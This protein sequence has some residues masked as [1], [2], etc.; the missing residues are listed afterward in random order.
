MRILTFNV[1]NSEFYPPQ[2]R[3]SQLFA[4]FAHQPINP[5]EMNTTEERALPIGTRLTSPTGIYIIEAVLGAGGFG[6]T[7]RVMSRIRHMNIEVEA[8]FAIK[9]MF[10]GDVCERES[11][12]GRMLYSTPVKDRVEQSLRDFINEARRLQSVG[13]THDNIVKINEVFE[14]NGTAYYVM[15]YLDGMSLAEYVAKNGP[16]TEKGAQTLLAPIVDALSLLHKNH[17]THLDIKPHNIM[18]AKG[19][20]GLVRPV[21]IDF[22]LSKH[23]DKDGKATSTRLPGGYSEGF[24]PAEQYG[25]ITA[26]SPT[27]DVYSLAATFYYCLTGKTPPGA[28]MLMDED[29]EKIIPADTSATMKSALL[30]AMAHNPARRTGS[31]TEFFNETTGESA[32]DLSHAT[33]PIETKRADAPAP[34]SSTSTCSSDNVPSSPKKQWWKRTWVKVLIG[35]FAAIG[36]LI[37]L[38]TIVAVLLLSDPPKDTYEPVVE[39]MGTETETDITSAYYPGDEPIGV[40]PVWTD[41]D[42]YHITSDTTLNWDRYSGVLYNNGDGVS[43]V[44]HPENVESYYDWGRAMKD[45]GENLPTREQANYIVANLDEINSVLRSIDGQPL[46]KVWFWTAT[47]M[48]ADNAYGFSSV[49]GKVTWHPKEDKT[50]IRTIVPVEMRQ[51][52]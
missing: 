23:Y 9:E 40:W 12:T 16:M 51:I 44:I 42:G 50:R 33:K 27:A 3:N 24:S 36:V 35:I 5:H 52:Q 15:E 7:Y 6:I 48:N 49:N 32:D 10:P 41:R 46:E 17:V 21:L 47:E 30:H 19:E 31:V 18:L 29:L 34:S 13:V 11:T 38:L 39:P 43:F 20:N 22:G 37:V 25:G 4:T 2:L 26:F 1:Q 45:W 14:A 8:R 28:L